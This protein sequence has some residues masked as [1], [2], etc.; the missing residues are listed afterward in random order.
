MCA[1]SHLGNNDMAIH[2]RP[3]SWKK[4]ALSPYEQFT[5]L[6][7]NED[8]SPSPHGYLALR[9]ILDGLAE[10]A[11]KLKSMSKSKLA[12]RGFALEEMVNVKVFDGESPRYFIGSPSE[13]AGLIELE[14]KDIQPG[15]EDDLFEFY[16]DY[17]RVFVPDEASKSHVFSMDELR[18]GQHP[19]WLKGATPTIRMAI[20]Y[21][22]MADSVHSRRSKIG[23]Y[24]W[25]FE[26]TGLVRPRPSSLVGKKTTANPEDSN[27]TARFTRRCLEYL[28]VAWEIRRETYDSEAASRYFEAIAKRAPKANGEFPGWRAVAD[29]AEGNGLYER[30]SEMTLEDVRR[31]FEAAA[32]KLFGTGIGQVRG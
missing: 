13:T 29:V 23:L 24:L 32:E 11:E 1:T 26:A 16:G 3:H 31:N 8:G 9:R 19:T 28:K 10:Q 15:A 5:S 2:E 18:D 4:G 20:D 12:D 6:I 14:L 25:E 7:L 21:R 27:N 17:W 30:N 22:K